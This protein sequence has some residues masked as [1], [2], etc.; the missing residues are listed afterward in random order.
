MYL[1]EF[2]E[3]TWRNLRNFL[4]LSWVL[5]IFAMPAWGAE[6]S[7]LMVVKDGSNTVPGKVYV[8]NGLMRQEF[9]DGGGETVTIV[10]PDKKVIWVIIPRQRTY[11]EMPL[12]QKLPG[13][14]IQIPPQALQRH[15][16][17]KDT[18]S[19][20]ETEK[21]A[22]MV[23]GGGALESQTYWVAPKLGLPVKMECRTRNFCL[24]YRSI[25]EGTVSDRLFDLPPGYQK[26]TTLAGF[27]DKMEE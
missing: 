22:V 2:M 19:G 7:A 27:A 10:R 15:P 3:P 1:E 24:E 9:R 26:L 5:L 13:Q 20:Y 12:T 8:R 14:F 16:V 4:A 23:P 25:K 17:G 6:F 18:V 21:I 11:L